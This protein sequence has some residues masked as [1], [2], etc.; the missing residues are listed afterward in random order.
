M[1][2]ASNLHRP[3]PT[4]NALVLKKEL[5]IPHSENVYFMTRVLEVYMP[6]KVLS[7]VG[8]QGVATIYSEHGT[9]TYLWRDLKP[10]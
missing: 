7:E 4:E 2:G 9:C 5:Q 1:A 10:V 6:F 3:F 8:T